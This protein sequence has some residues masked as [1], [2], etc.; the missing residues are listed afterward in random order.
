MLK[1]PLLIILFLVVAFPSVAQPDYFKAK[2]RDRD[3]VVFVYVT[4]QSSEPAK[5]NEYVKTVA[6]EHYYLYSSQQSE[7]GETYEFKYI[8]TYLIFDKKGELS[9]MNSD[10]GYMGNEKAIEW[11]EKAGNEHP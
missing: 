2:Y 3:D 11:M 10:G 4:N 8:P 6:G 7:I 1:N 5:W 9:A